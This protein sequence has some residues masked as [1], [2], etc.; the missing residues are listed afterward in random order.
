MVRRV[1]EYAVSYVFAG[2]LMGDIMDKE[3]L[4]Q[5][6]NRDL[7]GYKISD[8]SVHNEDDEGFESMDSIKQTQ[9]ESSTPDF[10]ALR[11]KYL[12]Q[13]DSFES[14]DSGDEAETADAEEGYENADQDEIVTVEPETGNNPFD[15]ISRSKAVVISG[16]EKKIIGEQ[17]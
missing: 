3:L 8:R 17:G 15:R 6:V 11:Q 4:K 7:S 1:I 14:M 12:R 2:D 5:I 16:S 10:K 9:S 13:D